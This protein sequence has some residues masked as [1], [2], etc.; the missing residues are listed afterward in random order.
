MVAIFFAFKILIFAL[1]LGAVLA[2]II[3]IPLTIYVIPYCL[4]IGGKNCIGKYLETKNE[5][6]FRS[7]RNATRLYKAWITRTEPKF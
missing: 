2:V 4:W 6:P 1:C 5:S 3:F 7:V